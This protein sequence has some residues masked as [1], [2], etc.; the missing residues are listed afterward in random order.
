MARPSKYTPERVA[1]IVE[2]LEGGN[3]RRAAA[4]AGG[5]DQATFDRWILRYA[6]FAADVRAAESKA[7][8]VHVE[9]IRHAAADGDWR[10]SAWWLERRYPDDW[11]RRDKV[12]IVNS[13]RE[14]AR[15]MGASP[16]EEA[17]AVAE[18]ERVLAEMR[19][20]GAR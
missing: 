17:A 11:G 12:E 16:E 15:Q 14:L 13:V 8:L 7:E 20:S 1:R 9:A 3:T 4:A 2:A 10:A 5:I 18:A 6:H 19:R